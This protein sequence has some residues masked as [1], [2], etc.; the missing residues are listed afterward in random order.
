MVWIL[1][2]TLLHNTL[3]MYTTLMHRIHVYFPKL[4]L[5]HS[6]VSQLGI[7]L[8]NIVIGETTLG[9]W[10]ENPNRAESKPQQEMLKQS[11]KILILLNR[12]GVSLPGCP[13]FG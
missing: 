6:S 7:P 10:V 5:Y 3:R 9:L 11:S 1:Y 12:V 13:P 8:S 4:H 2:V